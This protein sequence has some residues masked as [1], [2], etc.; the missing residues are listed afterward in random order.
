MSDKNSKGRLVSAELTGTTV[1]RA[2]EGASYQCLAQKL[3]TFGGGIKSE[4]R[5]STVRV[6]VGS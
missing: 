3:Q 2:I 5:S 1:G 4:V 6:F